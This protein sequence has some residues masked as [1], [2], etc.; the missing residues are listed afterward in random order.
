M[1]CS[2]HRDSD[3]SLD[4]KEKKVL[5]MPFEESYDHSNSLACLIVF[6]LIPASQQWFTI[7]TKS[8]YNLKDELFNMT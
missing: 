8:I 2:R 3:Q 7:I 5:T 4:L 1:E 6:F